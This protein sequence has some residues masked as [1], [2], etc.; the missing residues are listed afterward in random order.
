M[1]QTKFKIGDTAYITEHVR[2][3]HTCG[4]CDGKGTIQVKH[5]QYN[6]PECRGSKVVKEPAIY[7]VAPDKFKISSIKIE[8]NSNNEITASYKGRSGKSI[9][10]RK[11][12]KLFTTIEDAQKEADRQNKYD[13]SNKKN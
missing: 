4:V 8:I 5:K 7:I 3:T 9:F 2:V 6:C 1:L 13:N 12:D 11:E 10:N